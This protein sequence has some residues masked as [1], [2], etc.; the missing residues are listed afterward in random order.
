MLEAYH[1]HA[2]GDMTASFG[3][4]ASTKPMADGGSVSVWERTGEAVNDDG[5]TVKLD[6][7]ITVIADSA[8]VIT[9]VFGGGSTLFCAREFPAAAAE[10]APV[11]EPA[12][13][14]ADPPDADPADADPTDPAVAAS[15]PS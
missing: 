14:P 4:P 9:G 10:P 13:T 3:P 6:C 1:G 8:A 2:L 12:E 15:P 7:R 11:I 5:E